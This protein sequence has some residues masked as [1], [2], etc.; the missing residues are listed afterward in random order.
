MNRL[1]TQTLGVRAVSEHAPAQATPPTTPAGVNYAPAQ[2]AE[3]WQQQG[4]SKRCGLDCSARRCAEE[5]DE[6]NRYWPDCPHAICPPWK[7]AALG[8][9][10]LSDHEQVTEALRPVSELTPDQLALL[11]KHSHEA[12]LEAR[13]ELWRRNGVWP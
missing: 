12:G 7:Q 10:G 11:V 5:P 8:V 1:H 9:V 4:V 2:G 6:R 13:T 3:W